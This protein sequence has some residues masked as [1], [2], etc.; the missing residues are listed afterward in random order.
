MSERVYSLEQLEALFSEDS[1]GVIM[2]Q[3]DERGCVAE[4]SL[5]EPMS[6]RGVRRY[7]DLV[8]GKLA[9]IYKTWMKGK[10]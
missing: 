9:Y 2:M 8:Y 10:R 7:Y 4:K 5:W 1:D 3:I 6:K